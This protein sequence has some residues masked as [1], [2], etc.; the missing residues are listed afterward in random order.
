LGFV[1]GMVTIPESTALVFGRIFG[2]HNFS[3]FISPKK[4]W[5]GFVGQYLGIPVALLVIYLM[6]KIFNVMLWYE[7]SIPELL[8][9]GV[10]MTTVAIIGDLMESILKRASDIKD[11]GKSSYIGTGLGGLLD[12]FD[13]MGVASIVAALL[14]RWARPE[15]YPF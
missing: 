6:A 12:K 1:I 2:K 14:I 8:I 3:Y 11:S 4:T 5:E 13:S 15:H 9:G 10:I 7:Y